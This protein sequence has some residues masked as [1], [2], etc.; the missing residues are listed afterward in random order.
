[1]SFYVFGQI[2]SWVVNVI[3]VVALVV[4]IR[5]AIKGTEALDVYINDKKDSKS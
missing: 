5:L 1:M 4:I 3:Y 2:T